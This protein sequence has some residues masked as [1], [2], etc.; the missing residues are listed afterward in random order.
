MSFVCLCY[1]NK[2]REKSFNFY[3]Y[4]Y[5]SYSSL[6]CVCVCICG[7]SGSSVKHGVKEIAYRA[8]FSSVVD[9]KMKKNLCFATKQQPHQLERPAYKV[10]SMCSSKSM[11]KVFCIH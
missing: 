8:H 5:I 1:G 10:Q 9:V 2:S 6:M 3:N 11:L 7:S 4:N